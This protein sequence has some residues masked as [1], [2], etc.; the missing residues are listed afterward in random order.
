LID[1]GADGFQG[2]QE[3]YGVGFASLTKMKAKSGKPLLLIGSV[4]VS[5]TLRFGTTETVMKDVERCIDL[6]MTGR[7][8]GGYILGTDTN[9]GPDVPPE[10]LFAMC[11]HGRTY[12]TKAMSQPAKS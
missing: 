3:K 8:G 10:N 7:R 2:F 6:V 11:E 9:I 12:G 4:Q 1:A 5:T